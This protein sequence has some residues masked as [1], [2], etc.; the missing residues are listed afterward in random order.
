[1]SRSFSYS[2]PQCHVALEALKETK[3]LDL[4]P[5][6]DDL[7]FCG[8]CA[9]VSHFSLTGLV[10]LT[11]AEFDALSQDERDELQYAVRQCEAAAKQIAK[12]LSPQRFLIN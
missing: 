7:F 4:K 11:Q 2:C 10:L 3:G 8:N 9:A 5:S 6:Y 1:M 12:T